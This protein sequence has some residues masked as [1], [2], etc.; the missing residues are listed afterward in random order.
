MT[1]PIAPH[2]PSHFQ[3]K[4]NSDMNTHPEVNLNKI[5]S[6]FESV[7]RTSADLD[8]CIEMLEQII[9]TNGT[10]SSSILYLSRVYIEKYKL[11]GNI[12]N[13]YLD[14]SVELSTKGI[15]LAPNLPDGH[16]NRSLAYTYKGMLSEAE[17]DLNKSKMINPRYTRINEAIAELEMKKGNVENGFKNYAN[18]FNSTQEKYLR[19][20]YGKI[21]GKMLIERGDYIRANNVLEQTHATNIKDI[22]IVLML[23]KSL[24]ETKKT[25]AA[26]DLLLKVARLIPSNEILSEELSKVAVARSLVFIEMSEL[27]AARLVCAEALSLAKGAGCYYLLGATYLLENNEEEAN[28]NFKMGLEIDKENKKLNSIKALYL[29]KIN[30]TDLSIPFFEKAIIEETNIPVKVGLLNYFGQYYFDKKANAN[31]AKSLFE[32]AAALNSKDGL[33]YYYL[34]HIKNMVLGQHEEALGDYE[35]ANDMIKKSEYKKKISYE[36]AYAYFQLAEKKWNKK[37]I[38]RAL[39]L[40]KKHIAFYPLDKHAASEINSVLVLEKELK[41]GL[42][43]KI[44]KLFRDFHKKLFKD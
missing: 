40:Y 28:K 42:L 11:T 15:E 12:N 38:D 4:I 29:M 44:K 19:Y 41:S 14:R 27:K 43:G 9:K 39:E 23:S 26:L 32:Q 2:P 35:I 30:Q 31:V 37:Y 22:D 20:V 5:K 21:Y 34:G 6:L 10:D 13:S 7:E 18:A 36:L 1:S 33:T 8:T 25:V 24:V 16:V 3:E 17:A